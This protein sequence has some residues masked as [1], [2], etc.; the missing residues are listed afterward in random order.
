MRSISPVF[1]CAKR[2]K[3]MLYYFERAVL[4][5]W[6]GVSS[7]IEVIKQAPVMRVDNSPPESPMEE[8][9]ELVEVRV[10]PSEAVSNEDN[11]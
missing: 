8:R 2:K 10:D 1:S 6:L 11:V 9:R 7:W 3:Q 5:A 4:T